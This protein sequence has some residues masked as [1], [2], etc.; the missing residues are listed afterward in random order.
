MNHRSNLDTVKLLYAAFGTGDM[1]ALL[2]VLDASVSW[3]EHVDTQAI[4][5]AFSS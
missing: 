4:A 1:E 3:S 2:G 5:N